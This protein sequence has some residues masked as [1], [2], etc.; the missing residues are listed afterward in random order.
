MSLRVTGLVYLC[1]ASKAC[2]SEKGCAGRVVPGLRGAEPFGANAR[3]E[4]PMLGFSAPMSRTM[5]V[6]SKIFVAGHRG[7]VGSALVRRLLR[8][9]YV[10]L[11]TASKL[12]GGEIC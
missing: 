8:G 12:K 3:P 7:M 1:T 10:Q 2:R 9:G 11:I 5:N 4:V 6:H